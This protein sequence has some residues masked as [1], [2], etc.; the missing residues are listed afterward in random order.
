MPVFRGTLHELTVPGVST[1]G[2]VVISNDRWNAAM[3]QVTVVPVVA[4]VRPEERDY[5]LP[6]RNAAISAARPLAV[7]APPDPRSALGAPI[8][9]LDAEDL[10]ALDELLCRFL[11]LPTLLVGVPAP[12]RPTGDVRAYPVWGDV[13]RGPVLAG[14]R[15]RFVV[16]SP[17]EW[18]RASGLAVG[19][20]TT[21]QL[22]IDDLWF[23]AILDGRTRACCG[24][25]TTLP[26][27]QWRL[28]RRDRPVPF[29]T[30]TRDMVA[31]ARGLADVYD[32]DA[33]LARLA[34]R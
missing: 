20:R 33:A 6:Y 13:Y 21:T 29:T 19:V 3:S 2:A 25:A 14:E 18:N 26:H 24:D 16:V 1:L 11:Q 30:T 28:G 32:L 12:A 5:A 8:A 22:K 27:A 23:P 17:N 4:S 34:D 7:L 15:K 31:I 10:D 9:S